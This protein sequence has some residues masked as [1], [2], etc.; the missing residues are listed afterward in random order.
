MLSI[1]FQCVAPVCD[2]G[3]FVGLVGVASRESPPPWAS[4]FNID[5]LVEVQEGLS[6]FTRTMPILET[7]TGLQGREHAEP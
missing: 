2:I 1:S 5:L 4:N 3:V 7:T 6:V